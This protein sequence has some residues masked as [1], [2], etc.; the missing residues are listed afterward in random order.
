MADEA[1]NAPERG[2]ETD[3]IAGPRPAFSTGASA[4]GFLVLMIILLLLPKF[5]SV[6]GL[7][8]RED[9]Y[10]IMPDHQGPYSFIRQE[11]FDNDEDIDILFLGSSVTWNAIETPYVQEQLSRSLG[12]KARVVTFGFNF[13]SIDVPY[14]ALRDLLAHKNVRMVVFSIPR[15]PEAGWNGPSNPACRFLRYDD[16]TDIGEDLPLRSLAIMYGCSILRSPQDLLTIV[17]QGSENRS[18]YSETLGW[19]RELA[20]LMY[21]PDA[22]VRFTPKPPSVVPEDIIYTSDRRDQFTFL[23]TEID[24]HQDRYL[25]GMVELL[26]SKGIPLVMLN[27]P[28]IAERSSGKAVEYQN[29]VQRFGGNVE[30]IGIPPSTLFAGLTENEIERLYYEPDH[31]NLNG[32]EL[33]TRT[34]LPAILKIYEKQATGNS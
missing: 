10:R 16:Y 23:G 25:S 17:R 12:R 18:P 21:D 29:W 33:F 3:E 24:H 14:A 11:I 31:F 26:R 27:I 20:G 2:Q 6:T 5:I 4:L 34:V 22:F 19:D 7:V 9:S 30:L 15:D 28:Q 32:S 8:S 1:N 13:S